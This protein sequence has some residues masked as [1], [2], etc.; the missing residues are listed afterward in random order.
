MWAALNG[1]ALAKATNKTI[2]LIIAKFSFVYVPQCVIMIIII[3][4]VVHIGLKKK[5]QTHQMGEKT[6]KWM[7]KK[8]MRKYDIFFFFFYKTNK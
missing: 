1:R 8:K 4:I 2:C 5:V 7:N 3:I 6:N